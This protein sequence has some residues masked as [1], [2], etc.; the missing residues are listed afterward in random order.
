MKNNNYF[1]IF[2]NRYQSQ[3]LFIILFF[4]SFCRNDVNA[5]SSNNFI[6]KKTIGGAPFQ[7][8]TLG[9]LFQGVPTGIYSVNLATGVDSLLHPNL[10]SNPPNQQLNAFGFNRTDNYLWGYRLHTNE[11]VRVASNFSINLY[12]IA[13]LPVHPGYNVG[14]IDENG[15][16]YLTGTSQP[17]VYRI[18][19]N[20]NSV[21]Y[22]QLLPSL[23]IDSSFIFDW[24]VSPIDGN[25]YAIDSSENAIYRF[26]KITGARTLVGI[27]SGDG[28]DTVGRFG[29]SYMDVDGNFYVSANPGG[30]I[31][32]I[33]NPDNGNTIAQLF[34][35]G[36][37]SNNNDGALCTG[38]IINSTLSEIVSV[39]NKLSIYPNPFTDQLTVKLNSNDQA[40]FYLYNVLS[41]KINQ[42]S[43]VHSFSINTE[44]LS[45]GIYFYEVR[46]KN[47]VIEKGKL[48]KE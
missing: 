27:A 1:V 31:F 36:P 16:M 30:K 38:S 39:K 46:N 23:T 15:I 3:L 37:S 28:I 43:F 40:E 42:Q 35:S 10:I 14:D 29:A 21:S 9:Y 41:Q 12:P 2:L 17:V 8:D 48:I 4:L 26:N 24:S 20:P 19:I 45:A 13:G 44:L 7:C 47:G 18:D 32:K 34:S 11:L 25:I 22:L 33:S 6:N 5:Q